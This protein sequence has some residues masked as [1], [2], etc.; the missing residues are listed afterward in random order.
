[1]IGPDP[2]QQQRAR[3]IARQMDFDG[4]LNPETPYAYKVLVGRIAAALAE[5][6]G[7][8]GKGALRD[9]YTVVEGVSVDWESPAPA[10]PQG[11]C[12]HLRQSF[13]GT[14]VN[15]CLDCE[16]PLPQGECVWAPDLDGGWLTSCDEAFCFSNEYG[17]ARNAM[18]FCFHCGK[19]LVEHP[20]GKVE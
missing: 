17:P 20:T 4:F 9:K 15:K 3:D 13:P 1:M 6:G 14:A 10:G 5:A 7:A 12:P 16:T 19:K 11:D 2:E 8:Q 18:K